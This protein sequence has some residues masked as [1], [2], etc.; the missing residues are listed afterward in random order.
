MQS[1]LPRGFD[2]ASSL[3]GVW[4]GDQATGGG[5]VRRVVCLPI[6]LTLDAAR[7]DLSRFRGR[8]YR[9]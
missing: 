2:V 4:V 8:G 6:A 5:W 3:T 7:L 1:L 9:S